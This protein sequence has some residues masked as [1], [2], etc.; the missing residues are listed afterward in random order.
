MESFY[1]PLT[2]DVNRM[3]AQAIQPD[4]GDALS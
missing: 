3:A 1:Q 4:A 2:L